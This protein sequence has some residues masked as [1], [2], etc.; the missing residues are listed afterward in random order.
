M[1]RVG[2]REI[3]INTSGYCYFSL[4]LATWALKISLTLALSRGER[5]LFFL[6]SKASPR[7][8]GEG[9]GV[10]DGRAGDEGGDLTPASW[11][12]IASSAGWLRGTSRPFRRRSLRLQTWSRAADL[13]DRF[14]N[15]FGHP[16][17]LGPGKRLPA[18]LPH[19]LSF[20]QLLHV[21]HRG[22]SLRTA[23]KHPPNRAAAPGRRFPPG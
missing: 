17:L 4:L 11:R 5:E 19:G 18:L 9:L 8:P 14:P 6:L 10:R 7:P 23:S 3:S 2:G 1:F 13:Q 21:I 12:G 20:Q 22:T 16:N 15:S